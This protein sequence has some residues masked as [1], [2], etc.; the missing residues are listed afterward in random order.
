MAKPTSTLATL[1]PDLATFQEYDLAMARDGYVALEVMPVI[2]VAKQAGSFGK[3]PIEQLLQTRDTRRA[4]GAGYARS[5]MTFTSD[6]YSTEEH[7]AEEPIDDR[8]AE[9][10]ADY[11][12]AELVST[13]RARHSVIQNHEIRVATLVEAADSSKT[14]VTNEWDDVANATP[15]TDVDTL[16]KAY[17][18]ATG[19]YPNALLVNR[20]VYFNLRRC[21]QILDRIENVLP[22]FQGDI[23]PQQLARA[24]DV[25]RV[26]V[27]GG[28][29]NDANAGQSADPAHIWSGEYAHLLRVA[30][31]SDMR[32]PCFGRTVH[33]GADGSRIGGIVETYRDEVVRSNIVRCRMDTDEKVLYTELCASFDN[34]TT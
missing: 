29:K 11:F 22:T 27:A 23:G 1:R 10:Y 4:P 33:W 24:F 9:M 31:G 20:F 16:R 34:I 14:T 18:E 7:G 5:H 17:W 15:I 13:A 32:E 28:A 26:I 3:I 2:E 6:T 21:D 30:S 25:D 19:I 12:D 8:E